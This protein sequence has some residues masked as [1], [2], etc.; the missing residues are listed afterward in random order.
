MEKKLY[1]RPTMQVV[2]LQH[3]TQL[4]A[5]SGGR[6]SLSDYDWHTPDEE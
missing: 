2:M 1:E 4:L 5:G 6:G 3:R